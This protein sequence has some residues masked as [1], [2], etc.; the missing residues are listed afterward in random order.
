MGA[1]DWSYP[2]V[3]RTRVC[4]STTFPVPVL[5]LVFRRPEAVRQLLAVLRQVRP[6]RLFLACDAP[7]PDRPEEDLLVAATQRLLEQEIDWPCEV[8]RQYQTVNQGCRAAVITAVD[9]FFSQVEEG[10]ILEDDILPDPSF[11]DYCADLLV[12]YRDDPQVGLISGSCFRPWSP[13]TASY[14]FSRFP[15]IWGWASWRRAWQQYD[16]TMGDWHERRD[17]RWLRQLGGRRFE[18]Y[19][20]SCFDRAAAPD[21]DSIWDYAWTYSCWTRN[22]LCCVPAV[23]LCRNIGFGEGA[24]HTLQGVNPAAE[25]AALPLPLVHPPQVDVSPAWDRACFDFFFAP[26]LLRRILRRLM[27]RYV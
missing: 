18:R 21:N 7:R 12:R 10:I 24:T 3:G 1:L 2:W 16:P 20:R 23:N 8:Y 9:W 4:L 11:F 5:L 19:W 27:R 26:S 13:E 14:R 17:G 22:M 6:S 25:A 15:F